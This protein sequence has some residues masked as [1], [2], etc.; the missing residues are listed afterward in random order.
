MN[1]LTITLILPMAGKVGKHS[2][3]AIFFCCPKLLR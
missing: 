2:N 1:K 3:L